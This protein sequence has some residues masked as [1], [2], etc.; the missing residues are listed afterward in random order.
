MI[1][2]QSSP[3]SASWLPRIRSGR[4]RSSISCELALKSETNPSSVSFKSDVELLLDPARTGL[5]VRV[6]APVRVYHVPRVAE[7]ELSG[8]E[9]EVKQNLLFWR[10]KSLTANRPFKVE[11]VRDVEGRGLVKFVAHL[12][13]DEFEFV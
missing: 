7:L 5:R 12:E 4:R 8:M 9:G 10:G 13:E 11:F 1:V 2:L 3:A 6:K